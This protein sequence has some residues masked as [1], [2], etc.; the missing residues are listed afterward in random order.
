MSR[1][2]YGGPPGQIGQHGYVTTG[3]NLELTEAEGLAV[4][5]DPNWFPVPTRSQLELK[6]TANTTLTADDVGKRII[7]NHQAGITLTLPSAPAVGDRFEI[8]FGEGSSGDDV[9]IQPGEASIAGV[10]GYQA[11]EAE[12]EEA[13]ADYQADDVLTVAG[14]TA[15]E[16]AQITVDTVETGAIATAHITRVG[17]YT[18]KPSSPVAVTGGAGT[19]ATFNLTWGGVPLVLEEADDSVGLYWDGATWQ[20]F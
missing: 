5:A 10:A 4:T 19:G 9:T 18:V 11:L 16:T 13:G 7:C 6:I 15:S 17:V 20:T 1:Y 8:Y 2:V 12:I 14:G 3:Q